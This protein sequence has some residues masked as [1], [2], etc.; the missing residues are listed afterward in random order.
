M[1][2]HT[3]M[4]MRMQTFLRLGEEILVSFET[5]KLAHAFNSLTFVLNGPDFK[6]D[7]KSSRPTI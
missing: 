3:G 2:F 4:Q 7:L 6:R 5:K 1:D